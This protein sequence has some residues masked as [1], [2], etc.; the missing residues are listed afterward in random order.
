MH[1]KKILSRV[2]VTT[3]GI[4]LLNGF[5]EHSEVATTKNDNSLTVY[6]L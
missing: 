5:N 3:D 6:T 4:G 1:V 2:V